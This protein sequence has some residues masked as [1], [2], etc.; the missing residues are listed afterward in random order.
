MNNNVKAGAVI[1]IA[2]A[3]LFL[4]VPR[5]SSGSHL[6]ASVSEYDCHVKIV[7]DPRPLNK[8]VLATVAIDCGT[9]PKTTNFVAQLQYRAT[10]SAPWTNSGPPKQLDGVPTVNATNIN[11]TVPCKGGDWRIGYQLSGVTNA[12]NRAFQE[13]QFF[14]SSKSISDSQCVNS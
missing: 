13:A 2:A 11:V 6:H 3:L 4:I 14:G 8:E 1:A 10:G 12:T 5:S 7:D 9:P